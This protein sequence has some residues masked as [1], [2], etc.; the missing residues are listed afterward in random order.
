MDSRPAETSTATLR[1]NSLVDDIR[2]QL[3]IGLALIALSASAVLIVTATIFL[4]TD[5][6]YSA[7][8]ET[9]SITQDIVNDLSSAVTAEVLHTRAFL[10]SG[11]EEF[12]AN[13]AQ[14]IQEFMAAYQ[15]LAGRSADLSVETVAALQEIYS[16]RLAYEAYSLEV[17]ALKQQGD[18]E[19]ARKLFEAQS[20][21]LSARLIDSR[22]RLREQVQQAIYESNLKYSEET[23]R[24]VLVL[25]VAF[26]ACLL[27]SGAL[28]LRLL[29]PVLDGLALIDSSL[30]FAANT[31]QLVPGA[32]PVSP[33]LDANAFFRHFNTV[34]NRLDHNI[35]R[36]VE[37]LAQMSHDLRS[38]LA[39]IMGYAFV[40]ETLPVNGENIER[41]RHYI[42]AISRQA[43]H[44]LLL[45]DK[46]T[47]AS[48]IE[49]DSLVLPTVSQ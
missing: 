22:A 21:Q 33:M 29:K 12:L 10:F 28:L 7:S 24:V 30:A 34:I 31:G 41:M 13:R 6:R 27:I 16:A 15:L 44:T 17:I 37:F 9:L 38:P 3:I 2:R 39:A 40:A 4:Q 42:T 46:L 18:D 32:L 26:G 19:Q 45:V 5:G 23:Y 14:A 36:R 35:A 25:M 1:R 11:D 43:Q 8:L 49:T 48:K 20:P 47:T